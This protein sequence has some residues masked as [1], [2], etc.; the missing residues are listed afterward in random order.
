MRAKCFTDM[1]LSQILRRVRST[2]CVGSQKS[3]KTKTLQTASCPKNSS[4]QFWGR[5]RLRQFYGRLEKCV[6]SAGKTLSI[7]FRVL[8]GGVFWV[9][10]GGGADFIFMGARIFLKNTAN[11]NTAS[12]NFVRF[13]CQKIVTKLRRKVKAKECSGVCCFFLE[14]CWHRIVTCSVTVCGVLVVLKERASREGKGS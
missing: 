10:G 4:P 12:C 9:W 3:R 2:F 7:K 8:G 5:K 14:I 6:R 13:F 1:R 11:G